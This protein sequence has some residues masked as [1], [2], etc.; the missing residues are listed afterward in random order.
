M[1]LAA[2]KK[3]KWV[4]LWYMRWIACT[5]KC[6][7]TFLII[8]NTS[9]FKL[10]KSLDNYVRGAMV[11]LFSIYR[12][13]LFL[14]HHTYTHKRT[15]CAYLN[16]QKSIEICSNRNSS[17]VY[18]THSNLNVYQ[19]AA[20]RK[21]DKMCDHVTQFMYSLYRMMDAAEPL[22]N[23]TNTIKLHFKCT[24]MKNTMVNNEEYS[25]HTKLMHT[26]NVHIDFVTLEKSVCETVSLL[27]LFLLPFVFCF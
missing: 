15:R 22:N 21:N 16:I 26:W 4:T 12:S 24:S 2:Q 25:P 6:L 11:D 20:G 17:N 8:L 3:D 14:N 23:W 7:D 10:K 1:V 19:L 27:H 9:R 18:Y 13:I 5:F